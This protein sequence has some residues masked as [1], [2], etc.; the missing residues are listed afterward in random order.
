MNIVFLDAYTTNPGDIDFSKIG[1]L[2]NFTAYDYT[3]DTVMPERVKSA[4]VIIVNKHLV[5]IELLLNAP[6]LKY[7]VVA[8]TGYNN[9]DGKAVQSKEIPVSNVKG[10]STHGVAQYVMAAI[11]HHYNKLHFYHNEV[12][13]GRW[14]N[15]RDF[16]F[17]DHSIIDVSSLKL[18]IIGFGAIGQRV[19]DMAKGFDMDVLV[20]SKYPL[21]ESYKQLRSCSINEILSEADIV[22]LHT[23]LNAST[24]F[25]INQEAL[26]LMKADA[27]LINTGRG[28]LINEADLRQHLL[29]NPTFTAMVDVLSIEPPKEGNDLLDL[30]N[31]HTTPHIAWASKQSREKL[32]AGLYENIKS[33]IEGK[34][35][36]QVL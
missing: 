18:G 11:L 4:D 13:K 12:S 3:S 9:V 30:P 34:I 2:G 22:T 29:S 31:C 17:Y 10:Y 6:Q 25:L 19:A 8:A 35:I 16:C 1:L 27:L 5:S 15:S 33:F 23:P 14:T 7:I 32:V 24:Q 36:N 28:G 20:H 26:S 21:S